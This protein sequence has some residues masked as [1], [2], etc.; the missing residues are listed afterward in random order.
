MCAHGKLTISGVISLE[1]IGNAAAWGQKVARVL[2]DGNIVYG[3]ARSIGDAN[4]NFDFEHDV[5]AQFLRV[6]SVSGAEYF[7]PVAELMGEVTE[8]MFAVACEP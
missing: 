5:R 4:G 8:G 7:W 2:A 1:T 6:T 3:T